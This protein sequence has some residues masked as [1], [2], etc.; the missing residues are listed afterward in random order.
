MSSHS[1]PDLQWT[2]NFTILYDLVFELR[3]GVEDLHFRLQLV[4]GRL[5]TL[6]QLLST[7]QEAHPAAPEEAPPTASDNESFRK[8][9][10]A[11]DGEEPARQE[12]T[13]AVMAM[14]K[15]AQTSSGNA[16]VVEEPVRQEVK[17]VVVAI[18]LQEHILSEDAETDANK[19][20]CTGDDDMQWATDVTLVEEEPW[21]GYL[22]EYV[23]DYTSIV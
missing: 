16:E 6:L 13:E 3:Q 8:Q 14:G 15:Q 1:E 23:P 9:G 18:G 20:A 10:A 19:D 4:D 21:P 11:E 12:V 5:S 7:Y 22:P 2:E 17:E